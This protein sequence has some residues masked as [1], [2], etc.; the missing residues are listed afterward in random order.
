MATHEK[1]E[2]QQVRRQALKSMKR[3]LGQFRILM[4]EALRSEG[5][6]TAQMQ[7]LWQIRNAPASSG[8]HLARLCE[9]TPQTAQALIQRAEEDGWIVRGKDMTNER[10]VTASLTPSGE[11]L[12]KTADRLLEKIED[13]MWVGFSEAE[14]NGLNTLLQ[15]SLENIT[16]K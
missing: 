10:I 3:V 12:L 15:R 4:D 14:I 16:P 8:A 2:L 7:L 9:I 5:V 1:K 13:R 6:T 11:K